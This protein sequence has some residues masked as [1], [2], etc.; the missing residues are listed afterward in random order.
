MKTW[1]TPEPY[2]Q[3]LPHECTYFAERGLLYCS[4]A[5]QTEQ[6][7]IASFYMSGTYNQDDEAFAQFA[8]DKMN[9]KTTKGIDQ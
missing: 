1:P 4:Y 2:R 9:E 8:A 7:L 3:I 6:K 5:G